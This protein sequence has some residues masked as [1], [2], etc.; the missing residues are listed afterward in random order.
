MISVTKKKERM[1]REMNRTLQNGVKWIKIKWGSN[2]S[3][4][5]REERN[6][7]VTAVEP[8]LKQMEKIC[9]HEIELFDLT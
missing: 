5:K 8:N 2:G 4:E 6:W 1:M 7:K 9:P 3:G